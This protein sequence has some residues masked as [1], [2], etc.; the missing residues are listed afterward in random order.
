L[1]TADFV[2]APGTDV[3]FGVAFFGVVLFGAII[4]PGCSTRRVGPR[5]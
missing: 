4:A 3:L 2:E 1:G 5:S